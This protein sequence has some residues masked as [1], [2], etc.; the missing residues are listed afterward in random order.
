M[1]SARPVMRLIFTP[2]SGWSSYRV[3]DG[4]LLMPSGRVLTPKLSSVLTRRSALCMSSSSMPCVS[5]GWAFAK[6]LSGG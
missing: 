3:T 2:A 6:R 1:S 5:T 4:P